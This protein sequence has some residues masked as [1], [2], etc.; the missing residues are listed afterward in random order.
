MILGIDYGLKKIGL[1]LAESGLATPLT[2]LKKDLSIKRIFEICRQHRVEKI[3][4]GLPEG[5]IVPQVK[6]FAKKLS[7]E[8]KIPVVFQ[9]ET[10]TS[11][12]A[13]AKMIEA[14]K[15]QKARREK[16]DAA[17]AA[18][19]LQTYLDSHV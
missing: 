1:A 3:V 12:E 19:I 4:V 8:A 18:L 5:K 14:G 9:D 7:R 10:L 6:K 17:A 2:V 13:I 11:Q 15:G 16:E